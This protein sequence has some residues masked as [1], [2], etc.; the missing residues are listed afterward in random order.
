MAGHGPAVWGAHTK[1]GIHYS[2][3]D[4]MVRP[5]TYPVW[6]SAIAVGREPSRSDG[7]RVA[8]RSGGAS[9]PDL[10][11]FLLWDY[12][13]LRGGAVRT[14][15]RQPF[16]GAQLRRDRRHTG[17][18]DCASRRPGLSDPGGTRRCL[19]L[20]APEL[21]AFARLHQRL[22]N[23]SRRHARR[24]RHLRISP[25]PTEAR[26]SRRDTLIDL[27]VRAAFM[28]IIY[29]VFALQ[30]PNYHTPNGVAALL[31]GAVL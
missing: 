7:I 25:A 5:A 13:H 12:R 20:L 14:S 22:A 8:S 6:S 2:H 24:R 27:A 26:V 28:A 17:R 11:G 1:L 31:D 15:G 21:H 9:G 30:L 3:P 16:P 29:L 19:H 18:R 4:R 23:D 10:I